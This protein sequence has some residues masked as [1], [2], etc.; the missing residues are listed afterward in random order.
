M[1]DLTPTRPADAAPVATDWGQAV[2]DML[3]G[4]QGGTIT[5][6]S[7]TA[8]TADGTVTFPRA[9]TAAPIVVI[10]VGGGNTYLAGLVSAPTTTQV[11]FRIFKR[12][13]TAFTNGTQVVIWWIAVGNPA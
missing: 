11:T 13:G 10:G 5:I 8:T 2:H 6:T 9:Y 12:D 1:P 3:E 4:I 7:T